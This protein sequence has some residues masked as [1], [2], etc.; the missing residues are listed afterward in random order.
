MSVLCCTYLI[1]LPNYRLGDVST[2]SHLLTS[3]L[4]AGHV[5]L[6]KLNCTHNLNPDEAVVE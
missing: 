6:Q 1:D 3:M 5:R 2:S 4:H